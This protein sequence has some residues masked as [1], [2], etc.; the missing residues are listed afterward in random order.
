[1]MTLLFPLPYSL[2][3]SKKADIYHF[4]NYHLPPFVPG[5][6]VLTISDLVFKTHPK[7]M[8]YKT[9]IALKL[10][11]RKSL[12]R[13]DLII[14]IS[15]FTKKQLLEFYPELKKKRIETI[16][17]G[18]DIDFFKKTDPI[19]IKGVMSKYNINQDYILYLGTLEPRK[20]L[21]RLIEAY[22][23]VRK[24]NKN[25]PLLVIAGKRGWLYKSIF[26]TVKQFDLGDSIIFTGYIP[27]SEK[28][29]LLSGARAFCFPS[30]YEGFGMPTLE[31][32][33]CETPVL[34][35]NIAS[36]PE[37]CGDAA[38]YV[39]PLSVADITEGLE[40]ICFDDNLRNE[41]IKNGKKQIE[42]F[43]WDKEIKKLNNLYKELYQK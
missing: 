19:I 31:A 20:N 17:I 18:V 42:L 22:A 6:K 40:K 26:K 7:T 2:F 21:D 38:V 5:K 16:L 4:F 3:F 32:M 35:S 1:M 29:A 37:V 43:S 8:Y 10:C 23:E 9:R 30:I 24:K 41:L 34:T 33:A 15:D 14:T 39:N 27:Y 28:P 12:E 25:C 11:F 13:A 36:L